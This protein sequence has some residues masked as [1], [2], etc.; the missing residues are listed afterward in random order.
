MTNLNCP[1]KL[2]L[3]ETVDAFSSYNYGNADFAAFASMVLHD[4][5]SVL[6]RP[7]LTAKELRVLLRQGQREHRENET[8]DNGWSVFM[9]NYVSQNVNANTSAYQTIQDEQTV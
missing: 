8:H 9:A 7:E 6:Q 3:D 2:L 4:F 1:V 5:Q